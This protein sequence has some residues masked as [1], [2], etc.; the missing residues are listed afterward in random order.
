MIWAINLKGL[1]RHGPQKDHPVSSNMA[2]GNQL[3]IAI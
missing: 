2:M 3:K 1:A